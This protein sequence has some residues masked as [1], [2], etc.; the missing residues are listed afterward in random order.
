MKM[1]SYLGVTAAATA[2]PPKFIHLCY[3]PPSGPQ[4]MFET[5]IDSQDTFLISDILKTIVCYAQAGSKQQQSSQQDTTT[6]FGRTETS[7]YSD[8]AELLDTCFQLNLKTTRGAES[9]EPSG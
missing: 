4:D 8:L 1:G 6:H 7:N 9:P 2:N 5:S 3:K